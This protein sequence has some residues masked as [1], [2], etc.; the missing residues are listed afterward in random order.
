MFSIWSMLCFWFLVF[1]YVTACVFDLVV[2]FKAGGEI[3]SWCVRGVGGG[4]TSAIY[5]QGHPGP[6]HATPNI[7]VLHYRSAVVSRIL[8][9]GALAAL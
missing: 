6:L 3:R 4:G 5:H 7:T 1:W 9:S 8:P 2:G